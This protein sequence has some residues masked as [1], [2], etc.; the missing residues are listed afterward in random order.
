[1]KIQ[2]AVRLT[3]ENYIEQQAILGRFPDVIWLPANIKG[4]MFFYLPE[5]KYKDAKE[6]LEE[7]RRLEERENGRS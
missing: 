2:K 7:Y 5:T 4:E 1:M 6:F 3:A